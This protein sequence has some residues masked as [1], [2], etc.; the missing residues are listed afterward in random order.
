MNLGVQYY[1]APFPEQKYWEKDFARIKDSGLNTVQLWVVWAWVEPNPGQFCFDDYDRLIELAEKNNL[2]VILSTIAE[3]HP[4][5][6]HREV[7]GSEMIDHM[8]QKVISSNRCECHFGL[9]PGGCFDHPGIWDRMEKFLSE[10]VT[11]YRS[12]TCLRGWDAWNELRWNVQADGLVCFCEHTLKAFRRWLDQKYT[13]LVGL[14]KAWQRRYVCFDEFLPGKFPDRTYTEM[15]AFEHFITWRANRHGK[16]RY[17]LIKSLDP[18]HIVTVHAGGPSPL[19]SGSAYDHAINRGNDWFFADDMDGVGCSSFPKWEGMDD[20]DFGMRVEFAKSAARDKAVWL[21][22]VQGG[23]ASIG[24][25]IYQEV[26]ALSQQRWIWNGIA[27]GADTILFWCWRDE[28]FGRESSGFGLAGDDGLAEERLAAMRGTEALIEKHHNLIANY[29]PVKPEVGIIFS[30]QSYYLNWAQEGNADRSMRAICGY[31]RVLVRKSIP[32]LI[33]EEEHLDIISGLKVLFLPR[34]IVTSK[35]TERAL[36][37]FLRKGGTLVCESECGAF[38]P[39]GLY[40]YPEDRFTA[41]LS[42]IHEIGRRNLKAGLVKVVIDGQKLNLS[43]AQWLTPWQRGQGKVLAKNEDGDLIIEVPA[44]KGKMILCGTYLG[45]AYLQNWTAGF[46]NFIDILISKAG[47]KPQIQ[48]LSPIPEKDSF[49]YIKSGESGERKVVFIFSPKDKNEV[50]IHFGSNFFPQGQARDLITGKDISL[51][52][53]FKGQ[54]AMLH[55][56]ECRLS[57]LVESCRVPEK[58]RLTSHTFLDSRLIRSVSVL[59]I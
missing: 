3:I 45:D 48:V 36:E 58:I 35:A 23:R 6:I 31:A 50:H 24:F 59:D 39:Q 20:A 41:R 53:T 21:S 14:N 42:G 55:V 29:S 8:G 16:A 28:V 37:S 34:T 51:S 52:N 25:N 22:E 18:N 32:Y 7:P 46:E 57:I 19:T 44:G 30:P 9:T 4:Y 43:V 26:D 12:A 47:C 56:P 54:E 10:V 1:R 17:D 5:W 15:M 27:C 49:V 11:Q 38:N 40:R 13:G 2:G 33:V